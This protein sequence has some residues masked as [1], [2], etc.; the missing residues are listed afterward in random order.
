MMRLITH[1]GVPDRCPRKYSLIT[2]PRRSLPHVLG[3][4][5]VALC[6]RQQ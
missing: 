4:E 2:E 6:N 3:V 1:E 5:L